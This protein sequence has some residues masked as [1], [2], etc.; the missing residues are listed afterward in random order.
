MAPIEDTE[1]HRTPDFGLTKLVETRVQV[2]VAGMLASPQLRSH[3]VLTAAL[4][5]AG[6]PDLLDEGLADEGWQVDQATVR[7]GYLLS[8]LA[9]SACS[10]LPLEQLLA[11][12]GTTPAD[13]LD[14]LVRER[15]ALT[16]TL[17]DLCA[18]VVPR[19]VT[20]GR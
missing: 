12:P 17:L 7:R 3:P 13:V 5:D 8:Q 19:T 10:A 15:V 16:R 2:L 18:P 20:T 11:P 4:A 9:R 1:L 14:L 6:Q